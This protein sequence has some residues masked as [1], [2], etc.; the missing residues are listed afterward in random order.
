MTGNKREI[1][2]A[3]EEGIKFIHLQQTIKLEEDGVKCV[4]VT[5]E[6]TEQGT[7]YEED[8]TRVRKVPADSILVAIG[9]GPQGAVTADSNVSKTTPRSC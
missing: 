1:A 9:Q 4:A 7:V 6:E 5:V 2:D 8:F 3:I